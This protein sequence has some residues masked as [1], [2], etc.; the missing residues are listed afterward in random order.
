MIEKFQKKFQK[1]FKDKS[2]RE[3]ITGSAAS[4]F[5]RILGMVVS[6]VFTFIISHVYGATVLGA[7][8]ISQVV[9]NMFTMFS[10]AGMDT[11]IVKFFASNIALDKWPTVLNIYKKVLSISIPIGIITTSILFFGADWFASVVFKKPHLAIEF[12]VISFAIIPMSIRFINSESYRGFKL[13]KLYNYSRNVSYFLYACVILGALSFFKDSPILKPYDKYLPNIAFTFSLV[14]LAVS[15]TYLIFKYIRTFTTEEANE[16]SKRDI[17]KESLPMMLSSSLILIS[18]W[19]NTLFLGRYGTTADAGIY[20]VVVQVT[21]VC[22][23][24][25]LSVNAVAAPKFAELWASKNIKELG[26]AAR[27]TSKINFLASLP[28]FLIII[29][30]REFILG[31]FGEEFKMASN[32]L[33]FNMIG[34]FFNIFSGSCGSFLNMTGHQKPFQNILLVSTALN[35]IAC[36]IFIP[37]Y[38]LMGSAICSMIFMSSWNVTSLIYIKKKLNVKTYYWPFNRREK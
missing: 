14:L 31:L 15:S 33:L 27:Q 36:F 16:Y 3:L 30:F 32:I 22:G 23:F 17:I 10:R 21:T 2:F 1:Q 25:L 20:K 11:S 24:I 26:K 5:M 38:G 28:L 18:S 12:K 34:Q 9:L 29:I 6:Y 7:F 37:M 4:F 35:V 13:L 19:I 8:A